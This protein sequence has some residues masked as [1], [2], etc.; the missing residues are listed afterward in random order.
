M[1][2]WKPHRK[3]D[4][5]KR[6]ERQKAGR[7]KAF[8]HLFASITFSDLMAYAC[9]ADGRIADLAEPTAFQAGQLT[10]RLLQPALA[11]LQGESIP[12]LAQPAEVQV[13]S[14]TFPLR[15]KLRVIPDVHCSLLACGSWCG[16]VRIWGSVSSGWGPS[17]RNNSRRAVSPWQPDT[18]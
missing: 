10:V 4:G 17:S 15:P 11:N 7:K 9:Q 3:M 2:E 1:C 5:H 14:E 6:R 12:R 13:S 18:N 16:W 8:L